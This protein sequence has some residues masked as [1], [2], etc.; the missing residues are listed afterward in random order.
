MAIK[1][2]DKAVR[3]FRF[4]IRLVMMAA[5]V[6]PA[7]AQVQPLDAIVAVVNDDV[8]VQSELEDEIAMLIPEL[9]AR[10][11]A[12]PDPQ[13]LQQ[14]MLDELILERLQIQRAQSLGLEVD[15]ATLTEALTNIAARN[16]MG[17]MQL[18][19]ALEA[20]GLS[21][22]Q[23]REDTRRQI[24]TQRLQ[25]EDVVKGIQVSEQE[26]D[27]FM[28]TN[29]DSLI[30]RSEVRLS[31]IL[32]ALPEN[33]T[34]EQVE[35]ARSEARDLARRLR[36]GEDFAALARA[37]SDGGRAQQ[38]G[39]LGWFP[40]GEVPTLAAQ[41]AQRLGRGELTDPIRSPSGFHIIRVSDIKGDAPEPVTQTHA[42][43]ILIRTSEVVSDEDAKR[44]LEQLRLRIVGGDDFATLA[45]SHSDDTG[46]ALN[47]GDLGWVNPGD[48]VPDFE[49]EM[50]S[51]A[52]GEISQPFESPFGWHIVQVIERRD[53]D[54][55]DELLRL[56][57]KDALR[58]RKAEEAKE[59]WL[60]RL[61]DEAYV[62]IR[63]D[64]LEG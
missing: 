30:N 20:N 64:E 12:L 49:D 19:D 39:D 59:I 14:Q 29:R 37:R 9:Q 23:F 32:I 61:R 10:G 41:P 1:S 36:A 24:L 8:I 50:D 46:S 17:L 44:R 38:G 21:F 18:R 43:H 42:R 57:A 58:L 7:L 51:L 62:E 47:G 48:T 54:T 6:A 3:P 22:E 26:V 25:Q 63:L 13:T 34:D 45:R 15:E 11:A 52:P 16:N 60:Q 27:R 2:I 55:A 56:R 31:H 5:A 33:P 4:W 53:Q 40:I 35:Q 28:E